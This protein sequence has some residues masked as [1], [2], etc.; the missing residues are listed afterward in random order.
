MT[1]FVIDGLQPTDQKL[2]LKNHL[3]GRSPASFRKKVLLAH[4]LRFK[5]LRI[6]R[7][8]NLQ[9]FSVRSALRGQYPRRG[10]SSRWGF[11]GVRR[12]LQRSMIH[13]R[14]RMFSPKPGHMNWP[15]SFLRT[16]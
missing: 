16:S 6:N 11:S 4:D 14:T 2:P 13:F 15:L 7:L 10:A 8:Q 1:T 12:P 9:V 3:L 5:F